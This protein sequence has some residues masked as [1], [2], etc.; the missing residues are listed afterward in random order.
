MYILYYFKN[1]KHS[2]KHVRSPYALYALRVV[3]YAL[4]LHPRQASSAVRLAAIFISLRLSSVKVSLTPRNSP[5]NAPSTR[6]GGVANYYNGPDCLVPA[7]ARATA[8][9]TLWFLLFLSCYIK[10]CIEICFTAPCHICSMQQPP[11]DGNG[12]N[13]SVAY[14]K[15]LRHSRFIRFHY[16]AGLGD[17]I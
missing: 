17:C 9:P 4:T 14:C 6:A 2:T 16:S 13:N 12:D 7:Q 3:F 1:S 8:T 10:C 11:H 5:R 15:Y